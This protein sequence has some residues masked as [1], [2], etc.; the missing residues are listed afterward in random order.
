MK[1]ESDCISNKPLPWCPVSVRECQ[2]GFGKLLPLREAMQIWSES[3]A[4]SEGL[5]ATIAVQNGA[6]LSCSRC[7]LGKFSF[8]VPTSY[9]YCKSRIFR[10]HFPCFSW[11]SSCE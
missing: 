2:R 7:I 4:F 6:R 9:Q 5:R 3:H 11:E 10:K 8:G 1:R